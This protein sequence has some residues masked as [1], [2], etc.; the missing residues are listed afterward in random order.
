MQSLTNQE[1]LHLQENVYFILTIFP[2][3]NLELI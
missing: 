1:I 3:Y 2:K